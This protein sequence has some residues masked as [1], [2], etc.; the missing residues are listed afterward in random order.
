LR[1]THAL[2]VE[3]DLDKI[4][5]GDTS[6][7]FLSTPS[8]WRATCRSTGT[9][10]RTCHFY[11]RPPGGGR[12]FTSQSVKSYADFY[13]R[14]PGGG[15][16]CHVGRLSRLHGISIHALR[17]EGDRAGTFTASISRYF[18]PRP[19]GGGRRY[20]KTASDALKYFY[21]R[22][23]GGGR[24][25]YRLSIRQRDAISIHALRVEGD[26]RCLFVFCHGKISIHALRVEG[27]LRTPLITAL[28]TAFLSTPSG[29][30]A[31]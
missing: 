2:R 29:W 30:R 8:G 19:P 9:A 18:Y 26:A 28:H 1:S 16:P 27:D 21:P 14:P 10:V 7:V 3:G 24:L 4:T 20:N 13:P 12:R 17:V 5:W 22:P 25:I 15:R 23:P 6:K 31:T 11:P